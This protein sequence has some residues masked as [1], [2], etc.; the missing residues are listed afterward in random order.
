[1]S[2]IRLGAAAVAAVVALALAAGALAATV[3]VT[4]GTVAVT[5]SAAANSLLSAN[6]ITVTPVAPATSSAGAITFP[7]AGG[8]LR[9]GTLHGVLRENGGLD[10]SKGS[11]TVKL[12]RL[13]LVSDKAGL[14]LLAV[15][16]GHAAARCSSLRRLRARAR[17][18]IDTSFRVASVARI[19]NVSISNGGGTGT[20]DI[21][22]ATAAAI[23]HLAGKHV[24]SAGAVL[25][26]ATVTP[27]LG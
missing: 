24:T 18:A 20:V 11:E 12:R 25:G 14:V 26:T 23:N 19:T 21:T 1:M 5:P 8:R 2:R 6:G 10:I 13:R 27:T 16:R 9:S 7:I 3:K 15:V 17:C 4:G 22:A